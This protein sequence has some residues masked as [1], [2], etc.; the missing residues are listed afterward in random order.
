MSAA[1]ETDRQE[2]LRAAAAVLVALEGDDARLAEALS[3]LGSV[4]EIDALD[5][6]LRGGGRAERARALAAC[7][8]RI[9][10]ELDGWRL[11]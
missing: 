9:A 1:I 10:L 5:R 8:G 4:E 7:L 6:Q 11:G 3:G 2:A